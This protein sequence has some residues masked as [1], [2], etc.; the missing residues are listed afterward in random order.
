MVHSVLSP[1]AWIYEGM[2]GAM[3]TEFNKDD[4]DDEELIG[5]VNVEKVSI[6]MLLSKTNF[7][8]T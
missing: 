3:K 4:S 1:T 7:L 8:S 5:D 2:K 6:K